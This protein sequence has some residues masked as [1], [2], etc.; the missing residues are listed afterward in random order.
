MKMS[1]NDLK[2]TELDN[3][4][5]SILQNYINLVKGIYKESLVKIVLF[6]SY[7]RGDF[8]ENSDVDL[9]IFLN[10]PFEKERK[11]IKELY[12]QT[13][14]FNIENNIDIQPIPKSIHLFKKWENVLPF[15][16]TII[17]EGVVLYG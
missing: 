6:G 12:A 5:Y 11:H 17:E 14:D 7:A 4:F 15:Y 2:K 1:V 8:N 3:S 10:V 13:F 9:M 16:R